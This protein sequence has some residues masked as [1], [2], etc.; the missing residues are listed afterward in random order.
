VGQRVLAVRRAECRQRRGYLARGRSRIAAV[1]SERAAERER[2]AL[3]RALERK[4]AELFGFAREHCGGDQ[5]R[6]LAVGQKLGERAVEHAAARAG[7][8]RQSD[9]VFGREGARR[10]RA[11]ERG[12]VACGES[13]PGKGPPGVGIGRTAG[14]ALE[15][16]ERIGA[17]AFVGRQQRGGQPVRRGADALQATELEH[18]VGRVDALADGQCL[19]CIFERAE[20][21]TARCTHRAAQT[22]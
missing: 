19:A 22:R 20:R 6:R 13:V 11:F 12:H 2:V 18:G 4:L 1:A 5:G 8:Q 7:E 3:R 9:A 14:Q 17:G 15:E 21:R 16:P 10:E